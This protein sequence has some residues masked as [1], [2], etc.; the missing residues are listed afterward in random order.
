MKFESFNLKPDIIKALHALNYEE[1]TSIQDIAIPKILKKENVIVKS[2]TGS[3]K[4]HSFLIP[5]LNNL[6]FDR[7][8]EA[9][10]IV[11]T[12]ELAI[13]TYEFFKE[14]KDYFPSL[15][16]KLI[17]NG[18]GLKKG[19]QQLKTNSQIII[20]TP[21]RLSYLLEDKSINLENCKTL[22]LDEADMLAE[23]GFFGDIEKVYNKLNNPQIVVLSAT[24]SQSVRDFLKKNLPNDLIIENEKNSLKNKI[25]HYFINTKHIDL[26]ESVEIF[27]KNINPYLLFIFAN[28]KKEVNDIY[29]FLKKNKYKVGIISGELSLRERK[30][31]LRRAN[32]NDF[33]ILVCS[34]L[35]S[36]GIDVND[37]SDVLSV[38]IPNN[39]EYYFHR[40]GRT[41]RNGK[42]GNSYV[43]YNHDSLD[44]VN[45]LINLGIDPKYLKITNKE[46]VIDQ[47]PETKK[48]M[49]YVNVEL[50]KEINKVTSRIKTKNVKPNY[51]KKVR[52][53]AEKV[54]RKYKRKMIKKEIRKELDKKFKSEG[55]KNGR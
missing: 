20:A 54:K 30:A 1:A 8:I 21:T 37:V 47:K 52:V 28:T 13:Q 26:L 31:M 36:R 51:K 32:N 27:L 41:A 6:T 53:E 18:V 5:I 7:G 14:F 34:D 49:N 25:T 12:N 9:L 16:I 42:E 23:T 15:A 10:I 19:E 40:A 33:Q 22:V 35:A 46:L 38:N 24:I 3:G 29:L 4:T 45:Q 50:V 11:P 44:K 43:F 2:E 48:K 55:K 17:I 39:I